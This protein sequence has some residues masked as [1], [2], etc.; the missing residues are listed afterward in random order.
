MIRFIRNLFTNKSERLE[1][2]KKRYSDLKARFDAK[3]I[4][5]PSRRELHYLMQSELHQIMRLEAG[6]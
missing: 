4:Y 2:T 3:S 5:D 6:K 1:R